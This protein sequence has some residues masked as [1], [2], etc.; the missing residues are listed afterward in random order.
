VT[1]E[2]SEGVRVRA[3]TPGTLIRE[4]NIPAID[5]AKIDIEGAEQE[6]FEDLG[7][8]DGV[9]CVMIELHDRLRPGCSAIVESALKQFEC[10]IRGEIALFLRAS[11]GTETS[12]ET[13]IVR[14]LYSSAGRT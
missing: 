8:L 5:L 4:L 10:T 14:A 11:A 7:W 1:R 2:D 6:V 13:S 12:T 3:I 9:R